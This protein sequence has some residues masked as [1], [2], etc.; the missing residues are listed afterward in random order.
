MAGKLSGKVALVTGG[1]RGVGKAVALEL[2]SLGADVAVTGRT[3]SPVTTISLAPSVKR[4]APSR[5]RAC[6]PSRL[7]PICSTRGES[8]MS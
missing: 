2:A 1:S 7:A 8:T 4:P 5:R 6:G 3:V